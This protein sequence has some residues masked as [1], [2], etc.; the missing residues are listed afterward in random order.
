MKNIMQYLFLFN[1]EKSVIN[2][3]EFLPDRDKDLLEC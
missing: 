1:E 3:I 2:V